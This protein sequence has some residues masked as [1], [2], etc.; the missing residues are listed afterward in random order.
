MS[1]D[2]KKIRWG[3][4]GPGKIAIK[5]AEGLRNSHSGVL[6]A[7][8][9]RSLER[10]QAF[11]R[12]Q[13]GVSA[14][15]S[16]ADLLADPDVDA[17]YIATPHPQHAEWAIRAAEA[18]KHILCEKPIGMNLGEAD[19]IFEA[20]EA[21]GVFVMEAFMYRCYPQ[22]AGIYE[23]IR[24]GA[25]GKVQS[26]NASLA[27]RG[28]WDPEGRLLK[29][30]LGGGGIM[31]VGCY[32]VSMARLVAG[33]MD[34]QP[35]LEPEEM[36]GVAHIGET[37]VDEYA[38]AVLR[39]KNGLIAQ[40]Q[41]GV[42]LKA[43]HT[44]TVIGTAGKLTAENPWFSK[45]GVHVHPADG[46][47]AQH[48]TYPDGGY[49]HEIDAFAFKLAEFQ[50][51]STEGLPPAPVS[52]MSPEDTLG[53]MRVLDKWRRESGLVF[54]FENPG[55]QGVPPVHGRTLRLE[56]GPIPKETYPGF[57]KPLSVLAMGLDNQ[58]DLPF[59]RTILDDFIEKGGNVIDTAFVYGQGRLEGLL[60]DYLESRPGLRD[61]L[62]IIA[63][64]AHSPYCH[65]GVIHEQLNI[66]LE[67]MRLASVDLYMMHRDNPSV[68]VEEFVE[69]MDA[70]CRKGRVGAIGV[71]NWGLDRILAYNE[72]AES[73][74]M[75][76]ISAIS[77]N[78]SLA[79]MVDPVWQ[80]CLSVRDSGMGEWLAESQTLL[81]PWSSQARG[82]FTERSGPE[83]TEDE[84]LVRCWY[85]EANFERKRR[86][87][88]L[89]KRH[90]VLPL[91]IALAW[92]LAQPYP[93]CSLVGPRRLRELRTL[94]PAL[95]VKLS[96]A[97]VAWLDLQTAE[98]PE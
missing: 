70:E 75:A 67:R 17:V 20:G 76:R 79:E 90:G 69:A 71:S 45:G 91:N 39:F 48:H 74:G 37:G 81:F 14:H 18:G 83:K 56:G 4:L 94:L 59:V 96:K 26:L 34:G 16:Y 21:N 12:E 46:G 42:Q 28:P 32:P 6:Q 93:V 97:E 61:H 19:A 7:A 95:K 25:I 52:W 89:A 22:T 5:F 36:K 29:N 60:G 73:R 80:G 41:C 66:T 53:N 88:A 24:D 47:E 11:I 8:G 87:E 40:C 65:P 44:L 1:T 54:S 72:F 77:N 10:A 63:K 23:L 68:P 15:G 3:V 84:E 86:A 92:V 2:C 50:E 82:F 85:S 49:Q 78:H 27:F 62:F 43:D 58:P 38:A 33:A 13:G 31:D 51:E 35:F 64:G 55:P 30:E 57:A 98:M 9:S